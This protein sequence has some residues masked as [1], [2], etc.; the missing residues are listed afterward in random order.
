MDE[1]TDLSELRSLMEEQVRI[2]KI[3]E[4]QLST[5]NR[6]KVLEM[7]PEVRDKLSTDYDTW[8]ESAF[9]QEWRKF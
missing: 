5:A 7:K 9:K 4:L 2:S 8:I 1:A 6:L 3:I